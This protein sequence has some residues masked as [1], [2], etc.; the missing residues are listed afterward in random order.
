MK[1]MK[2]FGKSRLSDPKTS[3][4]SS[5]SEI[6]RHINSRFPVDPIAFNFF[7]DRFDIVKSTKRMKKKKKEKKKVSETK[8]PRLPF[9]LLPNKNRISKPQIVRFMKSFLGGRRKRKRW[10]EK[11]TR[12]E[13]TR[14]RKQFAEW[15]LTRKTWKF[16]TFKPVNP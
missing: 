11:K 12:E 5:E 4:N 14:Q 6:L 13:G 1:E 3:E 16:L 15:I 7:R 10:T 2:W 8:W 9:L